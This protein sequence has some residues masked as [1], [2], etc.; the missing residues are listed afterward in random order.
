MVSRAVENADD[1]GTI[2]EEIKKE[3]RTFLNDSTHFRTPLKKCKE[4]LTNDDKELT[5]T[6]IGNVKFVGRSQKTCQRNL[7]RSSL[8][9]SR[10]PF[11]NKD[12]CLIGVEH[13]YS[14]KD[15]L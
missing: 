13:G 1:A 4:R 15:W 3:V 6:A 12:F 5:D 9:R 8:S 11:D 14:S 10:G 2:M 7:M